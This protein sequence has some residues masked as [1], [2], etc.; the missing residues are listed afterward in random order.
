[1]VEIK[2]PGEIDAIRAAGR[3]VADVLAASRGA[4]APGVTLK[5]LDQAARDVLAQAGA[6]SPFLNYQRSSRRSRTRPS[7]ARR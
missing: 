4:A 5:E 6:T 3:V 1:M 7:S 2:T